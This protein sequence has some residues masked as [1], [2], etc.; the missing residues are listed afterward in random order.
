MRKRAATEYR[1]LAN[2][3]VVRQS[4]QSIGLHSSSSQVCLSVMADDLFRLR[5]T[6]QRKFS[7]NPSWA[8][9]QTNWPSVATTVQVSSKAI[10][11]RTASATFRVSSNDGAWSLISPAGETMF[12]A[13]PGAVGFAGKEARVKLRLAENESLFGLGETTGTFNK[14]G[15]IREF[16]NTDILGHVPAIHPS[17]RSLYVSIPFAV[18]LRDGRAAGIFW[19]NPGRQIWDLGQTQLDR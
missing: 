19:D 11:L 4:T 1:P 2:L 13:A 12:E 10:A 7:A 8:V 18:S 6:P 14:R 17:Q 5:V 3:K 9:H 16:W 15:L